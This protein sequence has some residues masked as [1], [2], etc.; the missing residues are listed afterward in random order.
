MST[1]G[2][3]CGQHCVQEQICQPVEMTLEMNVE[4]DGG[5]DVEMDTG[6]AICVNQRGWMCTR[7]HK[8]SITTQMPRGGDGCGRREVQ[9]QQSAM[10]ARARMGEKRQR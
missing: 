7:Q 8:V 1:G 5:M 2:N 10:L 3:V 9:G 6:V 4:T